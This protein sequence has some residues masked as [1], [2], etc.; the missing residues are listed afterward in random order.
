MPGKA[1][2][3]RDKVTAEGRHAGLVASHSDVLDVRFWR[4]IMFWGERYT[5]GEHR[6]PVLLDRLIAVSAG[7]QPDGSSNVDEVFIEPAMRPILETMRAATF[8][9]K[10]PPSV[11]PQQMRF[12]AAQQF[13]P[14][15]RQPPPL[16]CIRDLALPARDGSRRARYYDPDG[17]S[18]APLLLYLHGGGSGGR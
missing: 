4:R 5:P 9:N 10:P 14:W 6:A 12:R 18:P 13:E 7:N 1:H 15:N 3:P 2:A 8:G 17:R 11:T 16:T